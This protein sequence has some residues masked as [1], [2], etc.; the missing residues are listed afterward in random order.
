MRVLFGVLLAFALAACG[1]VPLSSIPKL[2]GLDFMTMDVEALRVAVEMP[3]G[4]LVRPGS[5]IITIGVNESAGGPVLQERIILRQIPLLQSARQ[6]AGLSSDAQVF[7]IAKADIPRLE[8]MRETVRARRKTDPDGTKGSLTVTSGACRVASLPKGPLPVTTKLKTAPDEAY[9]V[10]TR[11]VDL[12]TL[13][14]AQQLQTEVPD[15]Q[16]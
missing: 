12:R 1:H 11:N 13:V 3:E 6:S 2:K 4:L 16:S 5:A 9:F 15:C 7:R 14:S 10:M 8:A